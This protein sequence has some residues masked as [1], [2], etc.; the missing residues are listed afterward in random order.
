VVDTGST[1]GTSNVACALGGRVFDFQW[2]DDFAAAR[3][4]V[5]HPR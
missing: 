2:R 1:D 4:N 3:R 5:S